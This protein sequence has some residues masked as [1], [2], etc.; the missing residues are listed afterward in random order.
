MIIYLRKPLSWPFVDLLN[1]YCIFLCIRQYQELGL[2]HKSSLRSVLASALRPHFRPVT[3]SQQIE[4]IVSDSPWDWEVR[5]GRRLGYSSWCSYDRW[6]RGQGSCC[7]NGLLEL[8]KAKAGKY[9]AFYPTIA[10]AVPWAP[11]L[12]WRVTTADCSVQLLFYE[13]SLWERNSCIF[14]SCSL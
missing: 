10:H 8:E 1:P 4:N 9:E 11:C 6:L 14:H 7:G 13:T 5:Q 2:V 12:S 3:K